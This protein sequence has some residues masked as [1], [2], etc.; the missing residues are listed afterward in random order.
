LRA[1]SSWEK[2]TVKNTIG[3][4]RRWLPKKTNLDTVSDDKIMEIDRWLNDRP[5]KCLRYKTLLDVFN[6]LS[7][8]LAD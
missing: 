3:L 8:A 2:G 5:R 7:V 4:V 6:K 1:Y